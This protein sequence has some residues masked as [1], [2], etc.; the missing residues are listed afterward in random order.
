MGTEYR[1]GV[2][3]GE[4]IE[5]TGWTAASS[6]DVS[7]SSGGVVTTTGVYDP[8]VALD[9]KVD[10]EDS[11]V[12]HAGSTASPLTIGYA[13]LAVKDGNDGDRQS[14]AGGLKW[15][16][17]AGNAL[18]IEVFAVEELD[19]SSTYLEWVTDPNLPPV[20]FKI[21]VRKQ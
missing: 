3:G 11:F 15:S 8:V 6:I 5:W 1:V 12:V 9:V 13:R 2:Q 21:F 16:P 10:E 14:R 20:G 18:D 17:G 19:E 7:V 4:G